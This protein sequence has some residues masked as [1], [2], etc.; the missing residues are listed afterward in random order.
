MLRALAGDAVELGDGHGELAVD[1][2]AAPALQR[3]QVLHR[4]LA[5]AALADHHAAAVVLDGAGE[6]LRSRGAETV[7]EHDQRTI[8]DG[9]FYDVVEDLF[10]AV[11]ELDLHHRP[12]VDEQSRERLGFRQETAAVAAQV[13]D[14]TVDLLD[15]ELLDQAAHIAGGAAIV[16]VAGALTVVV[17]IEA[18]D[19]DDADTVIAIAALDG[20]QF[21]LRGLGFEGHLAA[22]QRDDRLGGPRCCAGGQDLQT[23]RGI[24]LAA[25]QL[26]DIVDAPTDDIGEAALGA[27]SDRGDPVARLEL[28]VGGGGAAFDQVHDRHVIIDELQRGTD[29]FVVEAHLDLVFLAVARR[30]IVGVRVEG[31]SVGV[32]VDLKHLL[33]LDLVDPLEHTLVAGA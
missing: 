1:G 9:A 11:G 10:R 17:R 20:L 4:A 2:L 25:D 5:E 18:R 12:L 22:H 21:A 3:D 19:V 29:A 8:V 27:L 6:D 28:A 16:D 23:H 33:G 32:E 15:L 30:E 13:D 7:D 14:E 24:A 31:P 26:H